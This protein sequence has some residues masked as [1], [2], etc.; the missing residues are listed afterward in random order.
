MP[1]GREVMRINPD[2]LKTHIA[3][4]ERLYGE[5]YFNRLANDLQDSAKAE[6]LL[7]ETSELNKRIQAKLKDQAASSRTCCRSRLRA[8]Y[9]RSTKLSATTVATRNDA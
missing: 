5:E 9:T 2:A 6:I 4:N 1:M 7:D 8:R 3:K